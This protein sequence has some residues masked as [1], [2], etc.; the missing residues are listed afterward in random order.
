MTSAFVFRRTRVLAVAVGAALLA[1]IAWQLTAAR[2]L[3]TS[4]ATAGLVH[5]TMTVT[6]LNGTTFKGDDGATGRNAGVITVLAYTGGLK[7][8]MSIGGA[9]GGAGAGKAEL[10]AVTITKVMDGSSPQFL[11]A[12]ATGQRLKSVVITFSR[13]D[14]TGREVPYY[15]ITLTDAFVS[16]VAQRSTG[17]TVVEDVS[18][19]FVKIEQKSLIQNTTFQFNLETKA[20]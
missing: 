1:L 10:S 9:T 13:T 6:Q 7:N 16:V 5:I 12:A 4:G 18:F 8:T 15:R 19:L 3:N 20:A 14:R 2:P 17:E 11:F